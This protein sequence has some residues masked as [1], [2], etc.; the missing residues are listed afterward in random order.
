MAKSTQELHQ[1]WSDVLTN[2]GLSKEHQKKAAHV[3]A[4]AGWVIFFSKRKLEQAVGGLEA[5]QIIAVAVALLA[6]TANED[7]EV[8]HGH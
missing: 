4:E 3:A 8:Q 2:S 7:V 6:V 1:M 5:A